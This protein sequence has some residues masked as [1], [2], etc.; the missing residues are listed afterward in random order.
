MKRTPLTRKTPLQARTSLQ[1]GPGLTRKPNTGP[2][3]KPLSSARPKVTAAEREG[4]KLLAARSQ[5]RCE[6]GGTCFAQE[7]HHRKNRSQGGTW[8]V[9]NLLHL[10]AAHHHA[11]T[12]HPL[13][14]RTQGWA[15]RSTD[16]PAAIPAW[17]A[18]KGFVYLTTDGQ[19]VP[20]ERNDAA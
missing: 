8:A 17:V 6:I 9:E 4:R 11:V 16:D 18:G 15:V 10:C 3:R 19:T 20:T 14:C 7:A 1:P 2:A 5:G 12:T 13:A